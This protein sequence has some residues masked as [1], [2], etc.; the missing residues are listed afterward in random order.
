MV[1]LGMIVAMIFGS[2]ARRANVLL[3]MCGQ[4][5]LATRRRLDMYSFERAFPTS[6]DGTDWSI[7]GD[8][9]AEQWL[10]V[11][12]EASYENDMRG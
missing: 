3:F 11:W 8:T 12:L 1:L 5:G 9:M 6:P 7:Y 4:H 10:G 2:C